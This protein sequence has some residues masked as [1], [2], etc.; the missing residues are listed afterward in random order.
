VLDRAREA[1]VD[2][3]L[4][5]GTSPEDGRQAA[6]LAARHA[7]IHATVGL[8]PHYAARWADRAAFVAALRGVLALPK[9]VAIG[10][11]GL[12]RHYP[13]P[14]LEDQR[15]VFGWQLEVLAEDARPGVVHNREATDDVLAMIRDAGLPG[16][17]FV[18]H[19]FT[20][21]DAEL[22]KILALDAMVGFTG[23]VTFKNSGAL[24]AAATR[25]PL[26]R[27]LIETDAPYLTPAPH[28]KVKVN[29]P[30]YIGHTARFLAERRGMAEGDFV[31]A[32]DANARRFFGLDRVTPP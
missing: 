13:E 23:I 17:R 10:E 28:R 22:D 1:G 26:D 6:A 19:C 16:G 2:G 18:F 30:G 9:V 15:R 11:M 27:V 4:S 32:V 21:T 12:D 7:Q 3:M 5:V 20:G 24:A 25:V 31:R 29:E 14:S 8:H